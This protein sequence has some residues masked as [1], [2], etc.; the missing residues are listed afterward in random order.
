MT[1]EAHTV[2]LPRSRGRRAF[3][4]HFAEMLLAMFAGMAVL[5]AVAQALFA[6][7]GSSLGNASG[8]IQVLIMGFNMTAAMVAWMVYR[9]HDAARNVE[10]AGS[11][12]RD[13]WSC[14]AW[15]RPPWRRGARSASPA[16]SRCSM[17]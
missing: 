3:A 4:R 12:W 7:G 5:G 6:A 16:R 2:A 10:M 1:A 11:R 15:P 14:R 8:A 13:P 9:G 17:P